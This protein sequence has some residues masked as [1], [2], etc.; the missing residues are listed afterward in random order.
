MNLLITGAWQGAK[1]HI[2]ELAERG[3]AVSFLQQEKDA[4]PCEPEWVE[5][6]VCN[7]LFLYHPIETF[8]NL[9]FI[10]LTSAGFDRVDM[11]CVLE[12]GIEIHNARGVYSIPMA[13]FAVSGV[14]QLYKQADFFRENR[15]ARRWEKH[16][17]LVELYGKK[18]VI[19]GCGSVGSECAKRFRA[20]GCRVVGIDVFPRKDEAFDAMLPL[21]SLDDM[22]PEADVLLLTVPLTKETEHLMNSRRLGLLKKTAV[23]VNISR[24]KVLDERALC[25]MLLEGGIAGAVLDVFETEPLPEDSPLWDAPNLIVTPHNSF[26]GD[27]NGERLNGCIF[28]NLDS[29]VLI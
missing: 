6:V 3:H 20:F 13:E 24:G 14:L 12:R 23:A 18:V 21:E 8:P 10:Q 27:G 22:L 29:G 16:R 4:L 11:D 28:D 7:G 26:V 9:R 1:E 2:E 15:K 19:I 17:G 5:G 25:D